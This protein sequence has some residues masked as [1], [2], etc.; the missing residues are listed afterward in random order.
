[1]FLPVLHNLFV[2]SVQNM[3]HFSYQDLVSKLSRKLYKGTYCKRT[4]TTQKYLCIGF[5]IYNYRHSTV[6]NS[7]KT[8]SYRYKSHYWKSEIMK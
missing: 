5:Y 8:L 6:N 7:G 2:L 1:M 4:F 3:N